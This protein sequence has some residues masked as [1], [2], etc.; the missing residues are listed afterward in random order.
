MIP[1]RE[2]HVVKWTS[3]NQRERTWIVDYSDAR[4]RAIRWLGDRYLLARPINASPGAA[5]QHRGS[6]Q[7]KTP[8]DGS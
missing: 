8:E 1:E 4:E 7:S 5:H 2:D 3:S 6:L